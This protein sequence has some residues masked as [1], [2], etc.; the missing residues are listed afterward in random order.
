M[1]ATITLK[2]IPDDLFA[3]LKLSAAVHHH[4]LNFEV[5]LCLETVLF[6]KKIAVSERL[7]RARELRGGLI[8][9]NFKGRDIEALKQSGRS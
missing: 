1:P 7:A 2:N 3:R 6:P 9:A 4:S 5:I 8:P